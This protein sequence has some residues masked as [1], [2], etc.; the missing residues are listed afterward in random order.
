MTGTSVEESGAACAPASPL[1]SVPP[2]PQDL[3]LPPGSLVTQHGGRSDALLLTGRVA[4][5]VEDVLAH[6]RTALERAGF[7]LQRDEDE[8]RAGELGFF[9]A[10]A[11][12]TVVVSRLT[13][14]RGET[15]FT[16]SVRDAVG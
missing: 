12:G 6:F 4:A 10:R 15:G 3:A 7:V 8:G 1:A 2:V 9:G 11:D 14:P 16:L 13:C 5:P